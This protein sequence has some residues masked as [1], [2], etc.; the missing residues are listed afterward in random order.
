MKDIKY[1]WGPGRLHEPGFLMSEFL[2]T[3]PMIGPC[4]PFG[5]K[6]DK[7]SAHDIVKNCVARKFEYLLHF[8]KEHRDCCLLVQ[9]GLYIHWANWNF[10][11][12]TTNAS[13]ARDCGSPE[14]ANFK[15]QNP[16]FRNPKLRHP[17]SM[18]HWSTFPL[19]V[20]LGSGSWKGPAAI[21]VGVLSRKLITCSLQSELV[22]SCHCAHLPVQT[23]LANLLTQGLFHC[24]WPKLT[25]NTRWA[26]H[27]SQARTRT[28]Y[29]KSTGTLQP[30][31]NRRLEVSKPGK[32]SWAKFLIN[33]QQLTQGF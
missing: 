27:T 12:A 30:Y 8:Q 16:A 4:E 11:F 22:S 6:T 29:E 23:V 7:T 9:R 2:E 31:G 19:E 5:G 3:N 20:C 25:Q 32:A 14:H 1:A 15:L 18:A 21:L 26:T 24:N 10:G 33:Q 17:H 13:H 28:L